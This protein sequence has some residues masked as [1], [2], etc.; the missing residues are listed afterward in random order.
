MKRVLTILAAVVVGG[1]GLGVSLSGCASGPSVGGFGLFTKY[2]KVGEIVELSSPYDPQTGLEW[3]IAS[4]D[5]G[6]LEIRTSPR[7]VQKGDGYEMVAGFMA[8][9]PGSTEVVF[10]RRGG[11]PGAS[12]GGPVT[13]KFSVSIR[14]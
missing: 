10:E 2:V 12:E 6:M 9:R 4:Y 7:V 5:S 11:G 1:A 3:R 14:E 13:R 8:K